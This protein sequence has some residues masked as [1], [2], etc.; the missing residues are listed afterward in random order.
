[1]QQDPLMEQLDWFFTSVNWTLSFPNSM[2]LPLAKIT[3]DHIPCKIVIGTSIPK[4]NIFR[5]ENY[6]P[7]HPGFF[8]TVQDGWLKQVRN[9]RDSASS[10]AGKL[11]NTRY[12]LKRW[13]SNLSN[14]SALVSTCNKVI[15]F[16]D[17]LEECRSLFLPEWNLRLII[18]KQLQT[19]LKYKNIYWRKRFTNNKVKFGDECTKFF[20]AMATVSYRRN[21]I[22]QLKDEHGNLVSD[23]ESKAALLLTAYKN[24]MGISLQ[25][26]MLFYLHSLI[27]PSVDLDSLVAPFTKEEIDKII[28]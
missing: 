9:A 22:T 24:R 15:F 25:P 16:L 6:W 3:S 19:L 8:D 2:V 7:E 12:N 10:L 4:S 14:L 20:H 21:T 18:K 27:S 5:F 13:S 11:K 26:R 23:H 1:M 28:K 17:S